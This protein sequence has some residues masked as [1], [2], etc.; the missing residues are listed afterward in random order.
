MYVWLDKLTSETHNLFDMTLSYASY[1]HDI[2]KQESTDI[3]F[4]DS[5]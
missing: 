4:R 2:I 1:S 5:K 3:S